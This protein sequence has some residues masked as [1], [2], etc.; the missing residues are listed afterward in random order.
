MS[1]PVRDLITFIDENQFHQ[2]GDDVVFNWP[3]LRALVDALRASPGGGEFRAKGAF[4]T[5]DGRS[6]HRCADVRRIDDHGE[7]VAI[8]LD[9]V[10]LRTTSTL[11]SVL[12]GLA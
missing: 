2:S 12:Q 7:L 6:W 4:F 3:S 5:V 11:V 8:V 1:D 10:T 9:T